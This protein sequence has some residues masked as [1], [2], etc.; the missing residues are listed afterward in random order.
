MSR[1]GRSGAL[2]LVAVVSVTL[3]CV[4][5]GSGTGPAVRVLQ[6]APVVE[7]EPTEDGWSARPVNEDLEEV[8]NNGEG[9]TGDIDVYSLVMPADGRLQVSL[10]WN[11]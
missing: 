6:P 3:L 2:K 9:Y 11:T 5:C 10:A 4:A 1:L 8:S 7:F